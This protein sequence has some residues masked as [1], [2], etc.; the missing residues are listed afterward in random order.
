MGFIPGESYLCLSG[1]D[2]H[3]TRS[4]P[5]TSR[6]LPTV[7]RPGST[8]LIHRPPFIWTDH[9]REKAPILFVCTNARLHRDPGGPPNAYYSHFWTG[10]FHELT[11]ARLSNAS[12][13]HICSYGSR[14][15]PENPI[16]LCK[17]VDSA[18]IE[19]RFLEY[20]NRI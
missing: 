6:D 15:S 11:P 12:S 14:K 13:I 19:K 17:L 4:E 1:I 8:D 3:I 18:Q 16:P 2:R 20:L 5:G 9:H 10:V 7:E